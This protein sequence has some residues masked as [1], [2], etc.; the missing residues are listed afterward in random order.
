MQWSLY[1]CGRCARSMLIINITVSS[2]IKHI[3]FNSLCVFMRIYLDYFVFLG[4]GIVYA[5]KYF[6]VLI[7]TKTAAHIKWERVTGRGEGRY[8]VRSK[9]CARKI[10]YETL[11]LISF[12]TDDVVDYIALIWPLIGIVFCTYRAF[13]FIVCFARIHYSL[14]TFG[15]HVWD[16]S[17]LLSFAEWQSSHNEWITN[18]FL[19]SNPSLLQSKKRYTQIHLTHRQRRYEI[20]SIL[21]FLMFICFCFFIFNDPTATISSAPFQRYDSLYQ[22]RNNFWDT[23]DRKKKKANGRANFQWNDQTTGLADALPL[24]AVTSDHCAHAFCFDFTI[25]HVIVKILN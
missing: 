9:E 1:A 21:F 8:V 12:V 14:F 10:I 11:I 20:F 16:S 25:G 17:I 3:S 22:C 24:F 15:F 19:L 6:S 2:F 4:F 7:V 13:Y 5:N 18:S 23:H